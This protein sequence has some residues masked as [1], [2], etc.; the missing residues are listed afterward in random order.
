MSSPNL[1]QKRKKWDS[2]DMCEAISAVRNKKMGYLM[3]A[4]H[5]KVPRTT[6][7]R[8]VSEKDADPL[9]LT[10]KKIGRKPVFSAEFEKQLVDYALVMEKK[11]YGLTQMDIRRL[12]YQV[13]VK[14]NHPTPFK[15]GI[16][17]RYWLK[18][19]LNR[20]KNVLSMRKPTG[21]SFARAIGF[22]KEKL[23]T[24]YDILENVYSEK[25]YPADRIFNVD[26]SG[27]SI[28][29]SKI[30][31]IIGRRGKKQIGALTSAER[32]SLIT[33]VVCM[34][35]SGI[36]VPPM[37]IF[38]RKNMN[39]QLM[40]GAPAG[41]VGVCHP[42]G[43][44]QTHLFTQWFLHFMEKTKP[45]ESSP[46]LLILDG[47]YSH[48]KNL[49]IVD[50]ARA[51]H[52]SIISLPPHCT[53]KIQ[54]LDRSFMSPLKAYYSEEIR[55]WLRNNARALSVY[56]ITELF[57]NAYRKCQTGEIAAN[58]FK[59][60]GIYP[61]NRHIFSDADFLAAEIEESE[62][63]HCAEAS[64]TPMMEVEARPLALM[65]S[66]PEEQSPS[67]VA[68]EPQPSTSRGRPN[69]TIITPFDVSPIPQ[70][71]KKTSN[72]GRKSA[73]STV[74][75]SSPYKKQLI[76]EQEKRTAKNKPKGTKNSKKKKTTDI[77]TDSDSSASEV[78]D[79]S[80]SSDI[81]IPPGTNKPNDE[82]AVCFFCNGPFSQDVRGE[83]WVKC[84]MCNLWVH[85]ECAG[86]ETEEYVCD[87]CK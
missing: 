17:G 10:S 69:R 64:T 44:I 43:W 86:C 53:H 9:T 30:P 54:P 18:G 74:I 19:F 80:S 33:I 37:I 32:G 47:H 5:F 42:S 7:F 82:D 78:I 8:L 50:L 83:L 52:V 15:S 14:N 72:R 79:D 21:T 77:A 11:F 3:A 75:S 1:Y 36:Y 48:T 71:R 40:K 31:K 6:L 13:A 68:I 85:N 25:N 22:T 27:L 81:V 23:D 58:G 70:T 84:L 65:E 39:L 29:Q 28:V 12:S 20:H 76:D 73:V 56:D 26:E 34:S 57:G 67:L 66:P 16:A 24:F 59:V 41:S 2:N 46:V 63:Q 87:Y 49:E 55:M 61:F 62:V 60:S 35:A 51:N 45:S 38:P 4:K